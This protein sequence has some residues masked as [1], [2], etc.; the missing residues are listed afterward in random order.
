MEGIFQHELTTCICLPGSNQ[1][2]QNNDVLTDY[3]SSIKDL[4][5]KKQILFVLAP[6]INS[7]W[8]SGLF[9]TL[10]VQYIILTPILP[11]MNIL[12]WFHQG[13][14][15]CF[16]YRTLDLIKGL[17]QSMAGQGNVTKCQFQEQAV[18]ASSVCTILC[19]S[20]TVLRKDS[21]G[22]YYSFSQSL[23]VGLNDGSGLARPAA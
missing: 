23:G 2:L 19:T 11:C 6:L 5:I 9:R 13:W 17:P 7:W 21:L 15:I 16:C 8:H 18:R 20:A 3:N 4:T 14:F 22:T 10:K 1:Q 12:P